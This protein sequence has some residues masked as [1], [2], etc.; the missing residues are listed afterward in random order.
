VTSSNRIP[1]QGEEM[2]RPRR[3][4]DL[5]V[6]EIR[7]YLEPGPIVLVTSAHGDEFTPSLVG[8]VIA[9][10]NHS[11]GLIRRSKECVIN[12]PTTALTDQVV[13]VG[14]TSGAEIDKF[15]KFKLTRQKAQKVNAPLIAECHA[16][17]ECRLAVG[18]LISKFNFFISEVVKAHVAASPKHPETLHYTGDGVFMVSGKIICRRS[19]FRPGML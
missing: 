10:R 1:A 11:F 15:E 7:R 14:N 2:A 12:L 19:Q 13:G 17:F 5:P 6:S 9:S 3:K 16:N 18:S 8:C 4:I